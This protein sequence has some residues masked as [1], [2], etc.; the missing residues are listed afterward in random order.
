MIVKNCQTWGNN[1]FC[2]ELL[3]PKETVCDNIKQGWQNVHIQ[4]QL[5]DLRG[6]VVIVLGGRD[7][8]GVWGGGIYAA[9]TINLSNKSVQFSSVP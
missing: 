4:I 6:P 2:K 9:P 3:A 7:R 8:V 5:N 1:F